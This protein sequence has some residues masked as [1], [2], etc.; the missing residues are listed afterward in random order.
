LDASALDEDKALQ[1]P[2]ARRALKIIMR[3]AEKE[4]KVACECSRDLRKRSTDQEP[5]FGSTRL[6]CAIA[7]KFVSLHFCGMIDPLILR[8]QIA[9][10]EA[11]GGARTPA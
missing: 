5:C 8:C 3:G 2:L 11:P 9:T 6:S 4:D 10:E 1:P 7:T